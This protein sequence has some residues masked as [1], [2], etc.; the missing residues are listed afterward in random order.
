MSDAIGDVTTKENVLWS[1]RRSTPY[2][3]SPLLYDDVVYYLRHYQN[4]MSRVNIE[5]GEDEGGPFRLGELRNI[6]ASPVGAD[7]RIYVTSREGLT[8]VIT[9]SAEPELLAINKLEDR[10][11]ASAA[12]VGSELILRGE[13]FLYSIKE[14]Y[15]NGS[16]YNHGKE[17][18][19][20]I[21]GL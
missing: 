15:Y 1:R 18:E 10:F 11:S 8:I 21:R 16:D 20:S 14:I 17:E 2:V 5:S 3:P 13:K 7:G 12:L 9:H 6:Y 4:V 19:I